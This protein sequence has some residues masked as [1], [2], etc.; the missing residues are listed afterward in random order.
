[1]SDFTKIG[2]SLICIRLKVTR[3]GTSAES[4]EDL[5]LNKQPGDVAWTEI[6]RHEWERRKAELDKVP[7]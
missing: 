1:M 4:Y 6:T 7:S 2:D 5:F 3:G